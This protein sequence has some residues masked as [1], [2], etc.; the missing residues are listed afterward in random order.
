MNKQPKKT[1]FSP[2]AYL[3]SYSS[4]SQNNSRLEGSREWPWNHFD[5]EEEDD[6]WKGAY[7][8]Q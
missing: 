2:R 6:K 7:V 4:I 1:V 3:V 8:G 5:G